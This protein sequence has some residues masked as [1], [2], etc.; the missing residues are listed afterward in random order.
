MR[1]IM[2]V[3]MASVIVLCVG[4]APNAFAGGDAAAGKS[5]FNNKKKGGCKT[6]HKITAKKLVGPGLIGVMG[7]HSEA[8][9]RKWVDNPQKVWEENDTETA[10]MKKLLKREGKKKTRMKPKGKLSGADIDILVAYLKTL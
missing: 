4:I 1:K 2:K 9:I 8:W 5:L 10:E 6:C 3:F 7:R